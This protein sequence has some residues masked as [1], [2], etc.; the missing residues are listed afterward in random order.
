MN[1]IEGAR[2]VTEFLWAERLFLVS[3]ATLIALI[4]LNVM[5]YKYKR[6]KEEPPRF[7]LIDAHLDANGY[8][9]SVRFQNVGEGECKEFRITGWGYLID[10]E[11]RGAHTLQTPYVENHIEPGGYAET[12]LVPSPGYLEHGNEE[13]VFAVDYEADGVRGRE[14]I[15]PD[16][17][18]EE[19]WHFPTK[20]DDT[21]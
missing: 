3:L 2:L 21:S 20:T 4:S 8:S 18:S 1:I 10:P 16:D 13:R 17:L 6:R 14:H 15:L 11:R 12:T 7:E 9:L 19:H 5:A